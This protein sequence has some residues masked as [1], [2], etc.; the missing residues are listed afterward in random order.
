MASGN[1][2]RSSWSSH[3]V[4]H[5]DTLLL[6]VIVPAQHGRM[7]QLM[8]HGDEAGDVAAVSQA[9]LPLVVLPRPRIFTSWTISATASMSTAYVMI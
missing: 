7:G 1:G 4:V 3:I 5:A 2:A 9:S 6:E 8:H